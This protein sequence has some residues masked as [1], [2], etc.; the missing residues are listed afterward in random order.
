MSLQSEISTH[1]VGDVVK[2]DPYDTTSHPIGSDA[3]LSPTK[4]S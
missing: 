1:V 4:L 2:Y 3:R